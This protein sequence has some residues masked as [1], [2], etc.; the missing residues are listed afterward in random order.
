MKQRTFINL[1]RRPRC[2]WIATR[3]GSLGIHKDY[4]GGPLFSERYGYVKVWRIMG[5]AIK[6]KPADG[7]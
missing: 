5:L 2:I 6:W 3:W 7:A 1:T 4:L